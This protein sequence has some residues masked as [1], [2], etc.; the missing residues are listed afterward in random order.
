MR[1]TRTM[2]RLL[3]AEEL[4]LD[5]RYKPEP[6]VPLALTP[7]GELFLAIG[8]ADK[9]A[10][11]ERLDKVIA[12][13]GNARRTAVDTLKAISFVNRAT[14]AVV[15]EHWQARRHPSAPR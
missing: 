2:A 12:T 6:G 3:N 8:G 5:R 13:I 7:L 11:R 4:R 14:G 15:G 10:V 1:E 9:G